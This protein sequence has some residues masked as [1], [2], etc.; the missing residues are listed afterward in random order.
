M[1]HGRGCVYRCTHHVTLS[2]DRWGDDV[3][4]LDIEPE[5]SAPPA[6]G[7]ARTCGRSFRRPQSF[8]SAS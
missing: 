6:V 5:S 8:I 2:A 7:V 1:V 4:L 3:R